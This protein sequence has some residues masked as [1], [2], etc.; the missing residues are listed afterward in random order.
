MD[1]GACSTGGCEQVT[2]YGMVIFKKWLYNKFGKGFPIKNGVNGMLK[3]GEKIKELRKAQNVTQEK[4]ADYLNVSAQAVSKWE[5]GLTL[6]DITLLPKLA[7]F[8]G[9][10]A[11][12]LLNVKPAENDLELRQYEEQYLILNRKGKVLEKIE[13]ARKVLE[14]HPRNYQWMLNLAYGLVSYC[15]TAAQQQYSREHNFTEEAIRLCERVLEDCTADEFRQSAIQILCYNYPKIGKK[16]E[17]IRLAESMPEMLLC[18]ENL[19][20]RIYTGEEALR[21]E[22]ENLMQMMDYCCGILYEMA[23]RSDLRQG[24]GIDERVKCIETAI[25]LYQI[26]VEG[27]ENSLFYNCR[28]SL[29]YLTIAKLFC[30]QRDSDRTMRYLLLAETCAN[31]YDSAS[32][33][34]EQTY[35]SVFLSRLTWNPQK[36]GTN[37]EGTLK[38]Q[39]FYN[40]DEPCF[41]LVKAQAPF[42]ELLKRLKS[43]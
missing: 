27:D 16:D 2:G 24:F 3:I 12:E 25:K 21:Q 10:S 15:A 8:F 41:D 35:R 26:I 29:Y 36:A 37:W 19:L 5:N 31:R 32:G 22:Q 20:S 6:P 7:D 40:L 18:R 28:L 1:R 13:L 34:G 33:G 42:R 30:Q 17:A 23:C 4:L 39:L 14:Q 38:E 11:D 43:S 9:V